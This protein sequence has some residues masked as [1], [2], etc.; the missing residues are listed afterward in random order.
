MRATDF[1]FRNRF[2]I[3]GLLYF[4]GF[5][6]YW[7]HDQNALASL[8]NAIKPGISERGVHMAFGIAAAVMFAAALLRTWATAYLSTEVMKHTE[9]QSATLVADGP[10]RYVRNPLYLGNILMTFSFGALASRI[11]AVVIIFGVIIFIYRIIGREESE[12]V[13]AQGESYRRF[14]A[15]VPRLFPSFTPRLPRSGRAPRWKQAFAGE[16]MM[17]GFGIT[18]FI[19][20]FTLKTGPA[21]FI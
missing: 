17:W 8:L 4:A 21:F 7:F 11:G 1:E 18:V 3:F 15:T 12:L 19:F 14:L 16:S 20:A 2:W 9:V 13:L 5:I 10:Y 6:P